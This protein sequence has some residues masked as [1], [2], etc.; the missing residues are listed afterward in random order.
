MNTIWTNTRKGR[1]RRFYSAAVGRPGLPPGIYFRLL[2]VGYF[3]GIVD[4]ERGM[5]W[6][7]GDSLAIREFVGIAVDESAADHTTISRTRRL[8][9]LETH[10][11]VF[12]WVIGLFADAGLVKGKRIGI[13]ATLW[14]PRRR[15]VRSYGETTEAATRNFSQNWRDSGIA[16]PTREDLARVDRKRKK[17]GSNQ[18]GV[19]PHDPDARILKNSQLTSLRP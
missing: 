13:D 5:A 17:R 12:E 3:G 16:T 19:N 18:E 1:C 15:C 6:R 8:I 4:C 10:R 2:L 9:D 11:E 7:E 14:R